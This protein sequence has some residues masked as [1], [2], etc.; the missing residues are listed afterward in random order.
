MITPWTYGG[1]LAL[2]LILEVGIGALAARGLGPRRVQGLLA[3]NL[4]SHPLAT[5]AF[6]EGVPWGLVEGIVAVGEGALLAWGLR[7]PWLRAMAAACALNG[8]TAA[9]GA[10]LG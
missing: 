10:A 6:I 2:T 5:A 9:L 1:W 7:A 3:V 4:L 8:V